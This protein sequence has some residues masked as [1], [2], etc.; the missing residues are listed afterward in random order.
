MAIVPGDNKTIKIAILVVLL[1]LAVLAFRPTGYSG[2]F[3][4]RAGTNF[5]LDNKTG[6]SCRMSGEKTPS[7]VDNW[8][9]KYRTKPELPSESRYDPANPMLLCS[10]IVQAEER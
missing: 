1:V 5:A 3:T 10:E 6:Q 7:G 2:R 8:M 9:E 4:P